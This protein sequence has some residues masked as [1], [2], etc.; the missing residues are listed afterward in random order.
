MVDSLP[1]SI[2]TANQGVNLLHKMLGPFMT[3]RQADADSRADL[4]YAMTG[5]LL[6]HI[7][8]N[9]RDP[10]TLDLLA[11]CGGKFGLD[12]IIRILKVAASQLNADAR[13]D[14]IGD[15][16]AANFREKA[17][18]HSDPD[19]AALW[20]QLLVGE[21]NQRGS[22]S[23]KTVNTLADMEPRD[24]Q[25]FRELCKFRLIPLNLAQNPEE[26]DTFKRAPAPAR[27]AVLEERFPVFA[28]QGIDFDSLARLDWLGLIRYSSAGYVMSVSKDKFSAYQHGN[29]CIFISSDKPVNFGKSEFLPAGEE[30]SE[31][32][33]PLEAPIEFDSFLAQIWRQ[34]G[35]RVARSLE[36]IAKMDWV[37][38]KP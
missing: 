12:N 13:P 1:D 36:E 18:T 7:E 24:A 29:G 34:R 35:V 20:A 6:D 37:P 30:L 4:Q 23:R 32:C 21:A 16:W 14:L 8:R 27:L 31:L 15:D 26:P 19:M 17:R 38:P 10:A 9:P 33:V 2:Q 25:L 5:Q 22:F 3:R 11:S 28:N